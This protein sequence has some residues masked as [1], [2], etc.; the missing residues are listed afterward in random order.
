MLHGDDCIHRLVVGNVLQ[1]MERRVAAVAWI[2][3][4]DLNLCRPPKAIVGVAC[5][6][7]QAQGFV[8]VAVLDVLSDFVCRDVVDI[9]F[10]GNSD[11]PGRRIAQVAINTL[12]GLELAYV[13]K[14]VA[15][16]KIRL[17]AESEVI[18]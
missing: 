7:R 13:Y 8:Y 14:A 12:I 11:L 10:T 16:I 3:I 4:L 5:C 6:H 1:R 9:L 15:G 18:G 17:C 2:S